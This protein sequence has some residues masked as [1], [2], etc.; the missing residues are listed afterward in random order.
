MTSFSA[1][2]NGSMSTSNTNTTILYVVQHCWYSGPHISTPPVDYMRLLPSLKEAEQVAYASAHWYAN[3]HQNNGT[4]ASAAPN[5]SPAVVRTIQLP[6]TK[7]HQPSSLSMDDDAFATVPTSLYGFITRGRLFWIRPV[8]ATATASAVSYGEAHCIVTN[9]LLGGGSTSPTM[10]SLTPATSRPSLIFVGPHSSHAAL[11][12]IVSTQR[13]T[14]SIVPQGAT[15]QW[16]PVGP[17]PSLDQLAQEWP[18]YQS[19]TTDSD[20]HTIAIA[21][22][23]SSS[24]GAEGDAMMDESSS[25][26]SSFKRVGSHDAENEWFH[27]GH[28]SRHAGSTG[29]T[30]DKE[31]RLT[32]DQ[33]S[34][35]ST[36]MLGPP[37]KKRACRP[38]FENNYPSF[39]VTATPATS[40]G[41]NGSSSMEH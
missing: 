20:H 11:Q 26:T 27:H 28:H 2:S 33:S 24:S 31:H 19:S 35:Y 37:T 25:S 6:S 7:P 13:G 8:V 10:A 18:Q 4:A 9:G 3:Q 30:M 29:S 39:A 40:A 34:S 5:T 22:S 14:D 1:A 15:V 36:Q 32:L 23:S 41:G 16:V 17:P 38:V 12:L 21:A